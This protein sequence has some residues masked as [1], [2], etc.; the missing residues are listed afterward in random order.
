MRTFTASFTEVTK[1]LPSPSLPVC[2]AC[3]AVSITR[4][5]GMPETT[6]D[7]CTVGR[8][9]MDTGTP[10]Y[11]PLPPRWAPQPMVLVTVMPV[12]PMASR[13]CLSFSNR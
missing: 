5:G 1:I 6:T 4:S 10:R 12:M 3:L 7:T 11:M 9:A 2:R 8:R 13:L